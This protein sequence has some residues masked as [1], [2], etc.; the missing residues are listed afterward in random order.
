MKK[1]S[2]KLFAAIMIIIGATSCIGPIEQE[3]DSSLLP[4]KW[5]S[6]TLFEKY[7]T[8]GDGY[9]WDTADDVYEEEAQLF[10]WTLEKSTLT[11]IHIMEMGGVVP[12]TYTVTEL[13]DS[14]FKYK[15]GYTKSY[16]FKKIN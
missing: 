15:D 12:K 11:H 9:T 7:L 4:G 3:F 10:E 14:T 16:S 8:N 1:L 13:T 2:V 5:Q 6:N